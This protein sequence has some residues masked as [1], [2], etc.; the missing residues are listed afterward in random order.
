MKSASTDL[1][2]KERISDALSGMI[3]LIVAGL[4][5]LICSLPI[6]TLGASTTALY[7]AVNKCVR[8][9]RGLLTPTFF[10]GFRSNF[11]QA[12][13]IWLIILGYVLLGV[14]DAYAFQKMGYGP[15]SILYILSRIF[16]APLPLYFPWVFAFLSRF[17]NTIGGT[18]KFC[19]WLMFRYFGRS[20]LLAVELTVFLLIVWL[21]PT[22]LPLLPAAFCLMMSLVIEPV[23]KA[24]QHN[25]PDENEDAWYNE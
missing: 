22:L 8:H 25:Y 6:I 2:K 5:W 20:L 23:F 10:S 12:T 11:R 15:G 7:Y 17:D 1:M 19:G 14:V 9:N 18:L 4:L 13:I 3:D 21:L 16:F 24:L